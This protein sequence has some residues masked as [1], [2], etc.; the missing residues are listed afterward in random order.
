MNDDMLA[1]VLTGR[2][3][4]AERRRVEEWCRQSDANERRLQDLARL[5]SWARDAEGQRP[6][7]RPP[8]IG[9]I[10]A[11]G[12]EAESVGGVA[13]GTSPRK[14]PARFRRGL[15][16][17]AALV[18]LAIGGPRLFT[19]AALSPDFGVH[20]FRTGPSEQA[21]V[22]LTDGTVVRLAPESRLALDEASADRSVSLV[23]RAYFSVAGDETR[24]FTVTTG[25]GN[26][27][28]LGTR[29]VLDASVEDLSLVVV[30]GRVALTGPEEEDDVEVRDRQMAR[31]VKGIRLPIVEV[32][33]PSSFADW[34]GDFLAFQNTP[35]RE[36]ATEIERAYNVTID[37]AD[38]ALAER[39]I[40]AWF[41]GWDLP[42]VMEVV[43]IV[44]NARCDINESTVRIESP[45]PSSPR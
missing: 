32:D 34:F 4:D 20:Q 10:L 31:V 30:E 39:T 7:S 17:A 27:K 43:C 33:D 18:V 15:M 8:E 37:I 41:A 12:L 21:T 5:L 9:S 35:L 23:G 45:A 42:E 40:T 25:A 19:T 26:V 44:A 36:A 22:V 2:A 14:K 29:F 1:R 24:P 28:V 6:I 3:T 38:P 16:A 11:A 13:S